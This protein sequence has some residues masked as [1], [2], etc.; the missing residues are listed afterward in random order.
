LKA[1]PKNAE[2]RALYNAPLPTPPYD[3]FGED[4]P[5]TKPPVFIMDEDGEPTDKVVVSRKNV[6]FGWGWNGFGELG[7]GDDLPRLS[8]IRIDSMLPA[9][10]MIIRAGTHHSIALTSG[11]AATVR[12]DIQRAGGYGPYLRRMQEA[13]EHELEEDEKRL[14]AFQD[15][16]DDDD[17]EIN[18]DSDDDSDDDN[19]KTEDDEG[20]KSKPQAKEPRAEPS[21]LSEIGQMCLKLAAV[22]IKKE[23][24]YARLDSSLL[25]TPQAFVPNQPGLMLD[26]PKPTPVVSTD[27]SVVS[28]DA[29]QNS[30]LQSSSLSLFKKPKQLPLKVRKW[31]S[32]EAVAPRDFSMGTYCL[33]TPLESDKGRWPPVRGSYQAIYSCNICKLERI[34]M[35]C[36]RLCHASHHVRVTLARKID[37]QGP[38]DCGVPVVVE[39]DYTKK[40][41]G[42]NK[43]VSGGPAAERAAKNE[44]NSLARARALGMTQYV[45][46]CRCQGTLERKVFDKY[47]DE[48]DGCVR[49][50]QLET[51]M[52]D[53]HKTEEEDEIEREYKRTGKRP[54]S[55]KPDFDMQDAREAEEQLSVLV[56]GIP[57]ENVELDPLYDPL[58]SD[59]P[60]PYMMFH[61]WKKKHAELKK[62]RAAIELGGDETEAA[63]EAEVPSS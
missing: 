18:F 19:K 31:H 11:Y 51:M 62:S 17:E 5:T 12:E 6:I 63:A 42:K 47:I 39:E 49:L 45:N 54:T 3:P 41:K 50:R 44:A 34:C 61:D 52:L 8:P 24:E 55:K 32:Q 7:T 4:D 23:M 16:A 46:R 2:Q 9:D 33:D 26:P 13:Y 59:E 37:L 20:A 48:L 21:E 56:N 60:I 29:S 35:V 14:Q 40:K 36:A 22:P 53:M 25:F 1:P 15:N 57:D 43:K 28:D 58:D 30:Q 10:T 38:C 27:A